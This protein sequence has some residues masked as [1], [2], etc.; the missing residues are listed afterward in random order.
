MSQGGKRYKDSRHPP[1]VLKHTSKDVHTCAD[2]LL[3]P[4]QIKQTKLHNAAAL[5]I[6]LVCGNVCHVLSHV[7]IRLFVEG[8]EGQPNII[9][10]L[11]MAESRRAVNG[12]RN[13]LWCSVAE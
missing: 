11:R 7:Y 10:E 1:L 4:T 12:G 5:W 9:M 2:T 13:N 3:T 8:G 6:I